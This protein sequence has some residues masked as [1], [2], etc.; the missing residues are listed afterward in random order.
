MQ[1]DNKPDAI[2][3]KYPTITFIITPTKT[4]VATPLQF[5]VLLPLQPYYTKRLNTIR[6]MIQIGAIT[7]ISDLLQYSDG[8]L[9][10]RSSRP[11]WL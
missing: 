9:E 8:K 4:A 11:E 6:L 1:V 2:T 10:W 5:F 7:S 3:Y